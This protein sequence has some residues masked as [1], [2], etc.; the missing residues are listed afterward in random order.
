MSLL[1]ASE[2]STLF[3][4]LKNQLETQ[5]LKLETCE[6]SRVKFE[7]KDVNLHL[8]DSVYLGTVSL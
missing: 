7:V 5:A 2:D 8:S 6:E 3:S 1:D 4:I